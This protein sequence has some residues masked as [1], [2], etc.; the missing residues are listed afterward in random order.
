MHFSQQRG[1]L[2]A[3]KC[4]YR[5][6]SIHHHVSW[7]PNDPGNLWTVD[8]TPARVAQWTMIRPHLQ[9]LCNSVEGWRNTHTHTQMNGNLWV[10]M[11]F[12]SADPRQTHSV[13]DV[14]TP[15]VNISPN[16]PWILHH[17]SEKAELTKLQ[18]LHCNNIFLFQRAK[19][20][21]GLWPT[22]GLSARLHQ[23]PFW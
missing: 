6:V 13:C 5:Y 12:W 11:Q 17:K 8:F 22:G 21:H 3:R 23:F 7:P 4:T 14:Y 16:C 15:Y 2:G 9:D 1:F 18:L 20:G 10:P 19:D